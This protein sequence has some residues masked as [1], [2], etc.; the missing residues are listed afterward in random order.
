MPESSFQ[1][2]LALTLQHEGGFF[3]NPVTGE[4]VNHGITLKFVQ[5]SGYKPDA[6]EDFIQNLSAAEA[7]QIYQRFFWDQYHIGGIGNQDLANKVFDLTVNMGPGDRLHPGAL[8]LLQQAVN[9]CGGQ[10][11]VDGVLGPVSLAQIN[12][13]DAGKLLAT[14]RQ[15]AA[16]R[17]RDIAAGNSALASDLNDWLARLNS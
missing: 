5:S 11:A 6:T 14:Y 10:C 13:L 8:T 17:Y 12:A 15:L 1:P 7:G 16:Q 9:A 3:H 4:I 2:A